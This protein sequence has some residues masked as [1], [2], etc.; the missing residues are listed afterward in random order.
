M[1]WREIM[2]VETSA[3]PSKS[4]TVRMSIPRSSRWVANAC[5]REW[6]VA[7]FGMAARRMASL[8]WRG[9]DF[10]CRW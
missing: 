6:Q 9:R 4:W 7:R 10:S 5:R 8:N 3:C 2:V 1:T